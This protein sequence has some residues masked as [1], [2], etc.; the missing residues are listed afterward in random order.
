VQRAARATGDFAS[1]LPVW[2]WAPWR[3]WEVVAPD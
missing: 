1:W 3:E 2:R